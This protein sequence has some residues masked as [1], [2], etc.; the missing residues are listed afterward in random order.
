MYIQSNL[1][2]INSSYQVSGDFMSV[3][4]DLIPEVIPS[5]KYHVKKVRF[6]MATQLGTFEIQDDLNC[7]QIRVIPASC[8][9]GL[10]NKI[11]KYW[12]KVTGLPVFSC[13]ADLKRAKAIGNNCVHEQPV[14]NT[15]HL[16]CQLVLCSV[17]YLQ[18][19]SHVIS[20]GSLSCH[21]M[22]NICY[23]LPSTIPNISCF[24]HIVLKKYIIYVQIICRVVKRRLDFLE[25]F[26]TNMIV[27][28]L[29]S[30]LLFLFAWF[31]LFSV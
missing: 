12:H 20:L 2:N 6:S 17:W 13:Y 15:L 4:H 27:H 18:Q 9:N 24:K 10:R 28:N 1:L 25:A 5:Q 16:F 11:L 7:T 29:T 23:K 8:R 21:I 31:L 14:S 30:F 3:L 19:Y 26:K 22:Y